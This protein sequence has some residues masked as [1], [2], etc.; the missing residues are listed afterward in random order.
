MKCRLAFKDA[1]VNLAK[2]INEISVQPALLTLDICNVPSN[3]GAIRGHSINFAGEPITCAF[4]TVF[5]EARDPQV[6]ESA[7][8]SPASAPQRT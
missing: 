2:P 3:S 1:F 5:A 7:D 4:R 6:I 8:E